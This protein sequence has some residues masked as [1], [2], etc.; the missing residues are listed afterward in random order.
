MRLPALLLSAAVLLPAVAHAD[1]VTESMGP[2][3]IAMG[4]ALRAAS[5]GSLSTTLNPAGLALSKTYELEATYGF[6]PEDS[7][8]L[9]SASVCDSV[10]TRIA[11]CL[12][13]KFLDANPSTVDGEW[14][15]T[16]HAAGMT[17]AAPVGDALTLGVSG[18]YVDYQ[19]TDG[20]RTS[21]PDRSRSGAFIVDAGATVKAGSMI[22]IGLVAHNLMG[23]DAG[24]FPRELGGGLAAFASSKVMLGADARWNLE[25]ATGRFGLGGELFLPMQEGQQGIPLR[26]GLLHDTDG[27]ST[28]LS[29]GLGFINP[30]VAVDLGARKG[31]SGEDQAFQLQ[32][33]VRLFLPN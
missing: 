25:K 8:N 3:A 26:L 17:L 11:A 12:F 10:T 19:E 27:S 5:F 6:R 33:S 24:E 16:M 2:R 1:N 31:V 20:T 21:P 23:S 30:R 14:E 7:A 22:N 4:E 15:R 13:Y 9:F 18:K 28:Y 32:I 29:G